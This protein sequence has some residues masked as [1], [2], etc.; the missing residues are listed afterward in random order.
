MQRDI[1]FSVHLDDVDQVIG[2]VQGNGIARTVKRE[3]V[4]KTPVKTAEFIDLR[5]SS[6]E[7][8]RGNML[9]ESAASVGIAV[10]EKNGQNFVA[11]VFL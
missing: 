2:Q 10:V 3:N 11:E 7:V 5:F 8:T 6:D 1:A 9:S 4:L